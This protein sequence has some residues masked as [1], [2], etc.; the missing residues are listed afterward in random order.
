MPQGTRRQV[1]GLLASGTTMALGGFPLAEKAQRHTQLFD[2]V[3]LELEMRG[4]SPNS[5]GVAREFDTNKDGNKEVEVTRGSAGGRS[6]VLQI[7]SNGTETGDYAAS[8]ANVRSR[9]L[10]L[11]DLADSDTTYDYKAGEDVTNA[12]PDEV[13][14]VLKPDNKGNNGNG[15]GNGNG[16]GD[17][18]SSQGNGLRYVC[19]TEVD[20]GDSWSTREVDGEITGDFS[21]APNP[22]SGH[23][24][25]EFIRSERELRHLQEDLTEAFSEDATV[26]GIGVGCG[27]TTT[28]DSEINTYFDDFVVAG[29]ETELPD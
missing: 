29:E 17:R 15:K 27:T 5:K 28:E 14:V 11:G 12:V 8:I 18:N 21:G 3:V 1:L 10:T 24:W 25:K 9:Q 13:W 4:L 6:D 23:P 26:H 22:G 20:D 2:A 16:N 7:T 19:R